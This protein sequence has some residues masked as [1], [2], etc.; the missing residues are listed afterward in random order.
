VLQGDQYHCAGYVDVFK[1]DLSRVPRRRAFFGKG[2]I[3]QLFLCAHGVARRAVF[4]ALWKM[5]LSGKEL[6]KAV[7]RAGV[8]GNT[9]AV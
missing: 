2:W 4:K 3:S 7:D 5:Q 8:C 6:K 1:R 9:K